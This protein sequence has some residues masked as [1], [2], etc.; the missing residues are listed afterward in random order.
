MIYLTVLVFFD[1]LF[2]PSIGEFMS[3][4]PNPA[5]SSALKHLVQTLKELFEER[6]WLKF[7]AP[8]N[9]AMNLMIEAS[10]LAEVFTWISEEQSYEIS[11]KLKGNI[12]DEVGDVFLTLVYLCDMLKIDMFAA[13]FNKIE[14]IKKK[15]PPELFKGIDSKYAMKNYHDKKY[16]EKPG[17]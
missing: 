5:E 12:A 9:L 10:E 11:E 7:H 2:I 6:D 3:S 13:T 14:K 1:L 15:Y 8:K 16:P 4:T 17:N